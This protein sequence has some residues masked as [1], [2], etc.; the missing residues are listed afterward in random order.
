[1]ARLQVKVDHVGTLRRARRGQSPDPVTAA[2]LAEMA[3]ADGITCH[4]RGDRRHIRERDVEILKQTVTTR[5]TLQMDCNQEMLRLALNLKPN[6]VTFLPE[7]SD[8]IT[9]GSGL[10]LERNRDTLAKAIRLLKDSGVTVGLFIEPDVE[11]VKAAHKLDADTVEI[12]TSGFADLS[13]EIDRF[14]MYDRIELAAKTA[15]RLKLV[16]GAGHGLNYHSVKDIRYIQEIEEYTIGHAIIGRAV[17]V[18]MDQAVK[19]M[20]RILR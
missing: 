8:E 11:T 10:D 19:E 9:T 14:R 7:R 17:M 1:M 6:A 13:Q 12:N 2:S 18:G 16:V 15:H 20:A 5:L 4:L 3:G